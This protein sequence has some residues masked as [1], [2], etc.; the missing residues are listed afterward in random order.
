MSRRIH[1]LE[2]S[3]TK[4]PRQYERGSSFKLEFKMKT[5]GRIKNIFGQN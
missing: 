4:Y 2:L 1:K 3:T 5:F